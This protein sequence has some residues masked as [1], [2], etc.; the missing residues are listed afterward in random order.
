[1]A[2]LRRKNIPLEALT[3]AG[4]GDAKQAPESLVGVLGDAQP[5]QTSIVSALAFSSDGRWLASGSWDKTILLRDAV[6]GRVRRVLNGHTGWVTSVAFSKDSQTLVSASQDGT[7]KFWPMEANA[8]PV[9]LH[10]DLDQ[11][12]GMSISSDGR[13]LAAGGTNGGVKVWKW[14]EWETPLVLPRVTGE[15][16]L[17]FNGN[18]N[19]SL[20]FSSDSQFLAVGCMDD[21]TE[22][23]IRIFQTS[24]GKLIRKLVGHPGTTRGPLSMVYSTDDKYLA[25]FVENEKIK[26]WEIATGKLVASMPAAQFGSVAFNPDG[27]SLAVGGVARVELYDLASHSRERVLSVGHASCFSCA[28]SADGK[29]L[30]AVSGLASCTFGNH[31]LAR[32]ESGAG[33]SP[34][35]AGRGDQS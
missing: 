19:S 18:R 3:A 32:K 34:K 9:T 17:H 1:M 31:H 4:D 33:A 13:F 30:L 11:I 10:P 29:L 25:S 8:T 21:K 12:W 14:G 27:K 35:C 22:A 23:P 2:A 24:D 16:W 28:F 20:A 15:V 7:L 26:V 6:T 5:I